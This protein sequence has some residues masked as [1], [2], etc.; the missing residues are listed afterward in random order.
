MLSLHASVAAADAKA[1]SKEGKLEGAATKTPLFE[2]ALKLKKAKGAPAKLYTGQTEDIVIAEPQWTKKFNSYKIVSDQMYDNYG[3]FKVDVNEDG[4]II[5]KGGV[6]VNAHLG[7]HTITVVATADEYGKDQGMGS[8]HTTYASRAT[9]SV[10]VVKGINNI[11]VNQTQR[12]H[13]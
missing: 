13:L 12:K 8:S 6:P 7:K 11:I 3:D 10:N 2:D 9:I 4:N 5:L 1:V